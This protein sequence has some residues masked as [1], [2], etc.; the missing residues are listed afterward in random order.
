MRSRVKRKGFNNAK[1]LCNA[2]ASR[3]APIA[4]NFYTGI[5]TWLQCKDSAVAESVM[6]KII[7]LGGIALPVHDSFIV[8]VGREGELEAAMAEAFNEV[9]PNIPSK[10]KRKVD[11]L[12]LR[13]ASNLLNDQLPEFAEDL[14]SLAVSDWQRLLNS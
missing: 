7:A 13:Q 12:E 11:L 9:Y 6:L 5:G 1:P 10:Y 8:R 14:D 2:L 3:H 4:A